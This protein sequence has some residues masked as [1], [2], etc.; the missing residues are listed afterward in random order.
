[1]ESSGANAY[2]ATAALTITPV[3]AS[4]KETV[5]P[6]FNQAKEKTKDLYQNGSGSETFKQ[7]TETGKAAVKAV[8]ETAT[9]VGTSA[10]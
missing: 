3:L 2:L 9:Y 4:A 1:M 7:T 5:A 6:V 10:F 8:A